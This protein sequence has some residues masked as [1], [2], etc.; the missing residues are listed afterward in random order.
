MEIALHGIGVSP[1]IAIGPALGFNIHAF[2]IPKYQVTDKAAEKERFE[3]ALADVRK[4]LERLY[5]H[6]AR[7]LDTQHADILKTHLM[8]LDDVVMHEE[9][10][11]RLDEEGWNAEYLLDDLITR[12]AQIMKTVTAPSFRER[13]ND[14]LDV[15]TQILGKL[16]KTKPVSLKHIERPS[17][18]VAHDL[19]PSDI[20]SID[21]K[22]ALAIATDAGGRT[23]HTSILARAFEIP[24]VVALKHVTTH[25][26]PGDLVIVDGTNGDVFLR[27][28]ADTLREY[29]ENKKR[30]DR[31]REALLRAEETRPITTLDDHEVPTLANIELPLEISHSLKV[32]IQGV[33]LYRTEY[34][35]LN[36]G[37]LPS[38]E[39]QFKAYSQVAAALEPRPVVL[40]TLDLGGDKFL[41]SHDVYFEKE[42][43][44][45]L[46]WRAIRLC[47]ERPDIFKAQLRAMLRSSVHGNVRIMFPMVSG[48]EE[49][50]RVKEVLE[51]VKTDLDRRDV[52]YDKDVK[53]GSMIEV[54]SAV[55]V[56]DAL[57]KECDFFSIGTN[58]LIQYTLAIDRVN[59]R[60]AHMHE[61]AHPAVLRLIRQTVRAAKDAKIEC[62]ICGEMAADPLF[63][64]LLIGLGVDSLS[65]SAVAIPAVHAEIAITRMAQ[66]KRFAARVM[67]AETASEIKAMLEKR[68]RKR[69]AIERYLA[70]RTG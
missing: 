40:R 46:G 15:S 19:P 50:R 13:I 31:K 28:D 25:V 24:A 23:S 61:P 20:A 53:V 38:E 64:E 44:P 35:F 6:T 36:R 9:I 27:P 4:D 54:P 52:P 26:S 65:M 5:D 63:T 17:I 18:I 16:L 11:T 32:R 59:E 7:K 39:E 2:D 47:L 69:G 30:V 55:V 45:Q 49:Y 41:D 43:N 51:E 60:V 14:L 68:Y 62:S 29:T 37:S 56:A 10:E 8:L 42:L 67:A 66:A 3:A 22:N 48:L 1:G 33:G 21:T 57:A 12:H 70:Q 34:L 58:D